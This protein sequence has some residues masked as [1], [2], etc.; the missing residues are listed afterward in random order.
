MAPYYTAFYTSLTDAI[1]REPW[2]GFQ[3]FTRRLGTK[4]A[5]PAVVGEGAVSAQ[6]RSDPSITIGWLLFLNR[7]HARDERCVVKRVGVG[8]VVERAT[9]DL[10]HAAS[11]FGDGR[12]AG[13]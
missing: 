7:L 1:H 4:I 2:R 6:L 13:P 12:V 11:S 3:S 8:G 9:G 5:P 10:Q